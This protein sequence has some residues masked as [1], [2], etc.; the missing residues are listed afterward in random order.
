MFVPLSRLLFVVTVLEV[1]QRSTDFL[2]RKGVESPRLQSELLLAH[3]L[4]VKR[5]QLYLTFDR[6][7]DAA[8]EQAMRELVRRRGLR[9][10][11]QHLVGSVNFCGLELEVGPAALIPRPETEG[12]AEEA[13]R[14]L[15]TRKPKPTAI[16]LG[17]GSG[18]LALALA[19]A[20]PELTVHASDL[21]PEA[22]DLARKNISRHQ[23]GNRI[24]TYLGEGLEVFPP[25]LKVDL[26]VSNPPYIP[27]AEIAGLEVEVRQ[28]DPMLALDGGEDGLKVFRLLAGQGA[29]YL[30][31]DGC[32][33]AEFGAGQE[34]RVSELFSSQGWTVERI[35]EDLTARPRIIVARPANP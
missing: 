10:P 34:K 28:F 4:Q 27:T 3:V 8:Q 29:R 33:M 18:C 13:V 17:T 30:K 15:L 16:D 9:E 35:I 23:I 25:G 21:S 26:L 2:S 22:L 20:V 6:V 31:E 12:L 5:M 14:F 7:L 24:Q 11:L 19:S 32:F 1:I